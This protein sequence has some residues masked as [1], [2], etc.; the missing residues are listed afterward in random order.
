VAGEHFVHSVATAV[1]GHQQRAGS[2]GELNNFI[3]ITYWS[4]NARL[5]ISL[6]CGYPGAPTAQELDISDTNIVAEAI[7]AISGLIRMRRQ[8]SFYVDLLPL[9]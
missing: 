5:D 4:W 3:L 1:Y 2:E 7:L 9:T 6:G 8:P